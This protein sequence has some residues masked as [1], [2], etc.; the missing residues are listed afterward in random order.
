[1]INTDGT[2]QKCSCISTIASLYIDRSYSITTTNR[3]NKNNP[4]TAWAI[5]IATHAQLNSTANTLDLNVTQINKV[6]AIEIGVPLLFYASVNLNNTKITCDFDDSNVKTIINSGYFVHEY[7]KP[8]QYYVKFTA[9]SLSNQKLTENLLIELQVVN[10]LD[11][12]GME[13]VKIYL[14]ETPDDSKINF[15]IVAYGGPPYTCVVDYGDNNLRRETFVSDNQTSIFGRSI[16]YTNSGLYNLTVNCKSSN[17][18]DEFISDWKLIYIPDGNISSP[19]MSKDG[20]YSFDNVNQIYLQRIR[21]KIDDEIELKLPFKVVPESLQFKI[22]DMFDATNGFTYTH[23]GRQVAKTYYSIKMKNT[24][25]INDKHYFLIQTNDIFLATYVITIQDRIDT[26][27]LL[28]LKNKPI[29]LTENE[30]AVFDVS[31]TQA[32]PNSILK[33]EYGDGAIEMLEINEVKG[34]LQYEFQ[35][36]YT[37]YSPNVSAIVTLANYISSIQTSTKV[38]FEMK[39]PEFQLTTNG[40]VSEATQEVVFTLSRVGQNNMPV[41]VQKIIFRENDTDDG[42]VVTGV[43]YEFNNANLF[44]FK[45]NYKYKSNGLYRS[46]MEIVGETGSIKYSVVIKVGI[47]LDQLTSFA[48]NSYAAVNEVVKIYAEIGVG[49]GYDLIVK[50]GD[51]NFMIIPWSYIAS[52]GLSQDQSAK[53]QSNQVK[54]N[55]QI[56]NKNMIYVLY[57]YQKAGNYS[58]EVKAMSP[59]SSIKSVLCSSIIIVPNMVNKPLDQCNIYIKHAEDSANKNDVIKLGRGS[60]NPLIVVFDNCVQDAA[61]QSTFYWTIQKFVEVDY[62]SKRFPRPIQKFCSFETSSNQLVLEKGEFDFG[63]YNLS[64]T[65]VS[66]TENSNFK[67]LKSKMLTVSMS[68][69]VAKINGNDSIELSWNDTYVLDFYSLSYDPEEPDNKKKL[70][71]NIIC[72]KEITYNKDSLLSKSIAELVKENNF[73]FTLLDFTLGLDKGNVKFYEKGCFHSSDKAYLSESIQYDEDSRIISINMTSLNL[74]ESSAMPITIRVYL[75][76]DTDRV[77]SDEQILSLN[78]SNSFLAQPI[79]TDLNLLNQQL[80]KLDTLASSN[81]MLA[82]QFVGSFANAINSISDTSDSSVSFLIK[83]CLKN[84]IFKFFIHFSI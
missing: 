63:N 81:P 9:I 57:Q 64:V 1:M 26:V 65:V 77:S 40:N 19:Y 84:K 79:T 59:F 68:D 2:T 32:Y 69:L 29:K 78:A 45:F 46:S 28:D 72:S 48:F 73:D 14:N 75:T 15:Q 74:N 10:R 11:K 60:E 39:L 8:G 33:F 13:E 38:P 16:T 42:A 43:N 80:E 34:K 76:D 3:C 49:N 47:D 71:F 83:I 23:S 21:N 25:L 17:K 53:L 61:I 7:S 55:A 41:K 35:H 4:C 27:P 36:V 50:F 5:Y 62:S 58:V 67:Q 70:N 44:T 37:K 22:V 18:P 31:L 30:I 52:N 66:K 54:P 51:G 56:V 12:N 24:Y 6:D 20:K 82:L